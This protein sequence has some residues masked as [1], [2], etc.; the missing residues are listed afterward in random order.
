M[1]NDMSEERS[2]ADEIPR[3]QN[4]HTT[5]IHEKD[6]GGGRAGWFIA[7]LVLVALVAGFYLISQTTMVEAAKDNAIADAAKDVGGAAQQ[8]GDAAED[9]ADTVTE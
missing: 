6:S 7:V 8:I 3:G 1:E 4:T 5:I 9:V 2:T